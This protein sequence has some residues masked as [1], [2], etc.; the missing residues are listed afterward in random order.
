MLKSIYFHVD[1]EYFSTKIGDLL[2]RRLSFDGT[3]MDG[4]VDNQLKGGA[5]AILAL[6]VGRRLYIA[7]CGNSM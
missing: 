3:Q 7:N 2:A 6:I 1:S 5:T 4:H